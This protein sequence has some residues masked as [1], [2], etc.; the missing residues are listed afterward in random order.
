MALSRPQTVPNILPRLGLSIH[1]SV[2][3]LQY[4]I[5]SL[6]QAIPFLILVS[7]SLVLVVLHVLDDS[8]AP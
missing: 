4:I 3:L 8:Y 6:V 5:P 1:E 7:P 2:S